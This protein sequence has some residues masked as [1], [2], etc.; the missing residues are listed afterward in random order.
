[1]DEM[2]SDFDVKEVLP[3]DCVDSFEQ[4]I[5]LNRKAAYETCKRTVGRPNQEHIDDACD[6]VCE[7]LNIKYKT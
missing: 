6:F 1:L 4:Q 7:K 3:I 2:F 5:R